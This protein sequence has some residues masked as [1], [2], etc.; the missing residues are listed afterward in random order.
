MAFNFSYKFE[1][2]FPSD[3]TD[4]QKYLLIQIEI[5]NEMTTKISYLTTQSVSRIWGS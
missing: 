2:I 3:T 5:K 4:P 1:P